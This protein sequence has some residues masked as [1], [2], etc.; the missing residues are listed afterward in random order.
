VNYYYP[1]CPLFLVRGFFFSFS[2]IP[3]DF[4]I[5]CHHYFFKKKK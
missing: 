1:C 3:C 5:D 4:S 2:P